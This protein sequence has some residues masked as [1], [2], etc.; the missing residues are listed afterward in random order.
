[1]LS[2]FLHRDSFQGRSRRSTWLYRIAAN[3]AL[4]YLRN[5]RR[6]SMYFD[7]E[8]AVED[9]KLVTTELS[10]EH[11][12]GVKEELAHAAKQIRQLGKRYRKVVQLHALGFT[13]CEISERTRLKQSTVKTRLYRAR[14]KL[15]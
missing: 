14:H 5:T 11:E 8:T 3:A 1:M 12:A 9:L 4:M 2:A 7:N 15:R 10:P 6:R 13:E